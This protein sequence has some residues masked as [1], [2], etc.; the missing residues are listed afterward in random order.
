MVRA[1]KIA[2]F[3]V[4]I[5]ALCWIFGNVSIYR[6][7]PYRFF[8]RSELARQIETHLQAER[9]APA[10]GWGAL[11]ARPH[12]VLST[13]SCGSA[14]GG[15][16]TLAADVLD[17]Q[18]WPYL[19]SVKLGCSINNLGVEGFGFDQTLL[20]FRTNPVRESIVILGM[21]QPMISVGGAS[22]WAFLELQNHL[23]QWKLTKPLFRIEDEILRLYPRPAPTVDAILDHYHND[24][25]ARGW[26]ALQFPFTL[27]LARALYRKR[28]AP[29]LLRFG[30]MENRPEL[31][32]EREVAIDTIAAMAKAAAENQDRFVVLLIPRPEDSEKPDQAFAA[33]L[34]EL[35]KRSPQACLIDPSPEIQ[36]AASRLSSPGE[37]MTASSHFGA[38]GNAAL[39]DALLRGLADCG[40]KP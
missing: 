39:A 15:S 4:T 32:A 8:D 12:P 23:P 35:A 1:A 21:S 30:P 17:N 10:T 2:A 27:S 26:T 36:R 40:I 20:L 13:K 38:A 28:A 6:G 19:A 11:T 3:L 22:S 24:D 9:D 33:M 29:D 34:P 25:Y 7:N 5:E 14:W 31:K 37:I 16:F 18:A